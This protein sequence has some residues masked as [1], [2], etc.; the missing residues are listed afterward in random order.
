VL[1]EAVAVGRPVVAFD[2]K[3]V[4]DVPT[5]RLVPEGRIDQLAHEI[6]DLS[7]TSNQLNFPDPAL[8]DQSHTA[9]ALSRFC[10]LIKS[11]DL[12]A[13]QIIDN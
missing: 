9:D 4:R 8:L 11:G 7:Q 1:L 5:A 2:V 10:H 3:G 13:G 6:A 12:R